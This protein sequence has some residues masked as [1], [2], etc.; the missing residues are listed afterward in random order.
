MKSFLVAFSLLCTIVGSGCMTLHP[1]TVSTDE[2]RRLILAGELLKPGDNVRLVTA[3]QQ[4]HKFRVAAVDVDAGVVSGEGDA[5]RIAEIVGVATRDFAVGKTVGLVVG[6]IA[7]L[8]LSEGV[9]DTATLG[10]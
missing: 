5:V 8:Q 10:P 2:V 3:D 7:A 4:V 1:T 9:A 6:I